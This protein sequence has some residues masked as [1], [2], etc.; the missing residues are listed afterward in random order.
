MTPKSPESG[1]IPQERAPQQELMEQGIRLFLEGLGVPLDAPHLADTPQ[2]VRACWQKDLLDGYQ[3]DPAEILG[4]H[5]LAQSD[6]FILVRDIRFHGV[7]PHHL[8]PFFGT[9]HVAYVPKQ[10]IVGFSQLGELVRCLTHRLTLQELATH[11]IAQ[12]LM[13][14]LDAAGAACVM[15]TTQLC[16]NLRSAEHT[17]SSVVTSCFLGTLR[18]SPT[19]QQRVLG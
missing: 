13:E 15:E 16:M 2:R 1:H 4:D 6:D 12:A 9:A 8:L 5:F 3:L 10:H 18:E 17:H 11:Q 19:L 14:H 7:C